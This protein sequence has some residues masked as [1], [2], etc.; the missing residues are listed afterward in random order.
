MPTQTKPTYENFRDCAE[1][2][3]KN[4][5]FLVLIDGCFTI[6]DHPLGGASWQIDLGRTE[7]DITLEAFDAILILAGIGE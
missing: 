4:R 6:S 7:I 2:A 3:K 1:R 5:I